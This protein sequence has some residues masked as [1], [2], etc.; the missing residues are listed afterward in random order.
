MGGLASALRSGSEITCED[1]GD[2]WMHYS[3]AHLDGM[4]PLQELSKIGK[5][6]D[7][8]QWLEKNEDRIVKMIHQAYSQR[9][10]SQSQSD[11]GD[12]AADFTVSP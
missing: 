1:W 9:I 4:E 8:D 5:Y 2:D 10:K 3:L 6:R 7:L 11:G 12:N